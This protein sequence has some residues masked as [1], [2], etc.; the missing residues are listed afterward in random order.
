M[1][2]DFAEQRRAMVDRQLAARG[3]H[4]P[5]VLRAMG[6]VPREAFIPAGSAQFAYADSP[7]PIGEGQTISQP[8][9]VALMTE[10]L[11]LSPDDRVLWDQ[12]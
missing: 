10:M 8:Y 2:R 9:I 5:D 6:Q 11:A 3:I 1:R 7:L 4:D 12:K